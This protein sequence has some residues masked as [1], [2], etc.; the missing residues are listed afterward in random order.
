MQP[1]YEVFKS[2]YPQCGS[3][4][5]T[6]LPNVI[7]VVEKFQRQGYTASIRQIYYQL[8]SHY[9]LPNTKDGYDKVQE[10]LVH[11]RRGGYVP[12]NSIV[13]RGREIDGRL[14]GNGENETVEEGIA[15]CIQMARGAADYYSLDPWRELAEVPLIMVE[16]DALSGVLAP[17]CRQHGVPFISAH[18]NPSITL[19]KD[20]ADM[21]IARAEGGDSKYIL[22]HLTDHDPAGLY[23]MVS[24]LT[25]DDSDVQLFGAELGVDW[26]YRR[27]GLT[28]DQVQRY[29]LP[30]NPLK[31]HSNAAQYREQY[32]PESWELDA[33]DAEVLAEIVTKEINNYKDLI[34]WGR[35][36]EQEQ[37]V[38]DGFAERIG[39]LLDGV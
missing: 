6:N 33:L 22:L 13:D 28:L 20:L 23:G 31:D 11:A 35:I 14:R 10:L 21:M 7:E 4:N 8:V 1:K 15:S 38:R 3:W 2:Y 26:E 5:Y 18:G 30:P 19:L 32:G 34:V 25:S 39:P 36:A 29:G 37:S 16:K 17:I 24:Q 9:G 12:F 27:I